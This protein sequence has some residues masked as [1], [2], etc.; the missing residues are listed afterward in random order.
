MFDIENN[1]YFIFGF[2]VGA[3]VITIEWIIV[4]LSAGGKL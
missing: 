3:I 1:L 4:I 2:I